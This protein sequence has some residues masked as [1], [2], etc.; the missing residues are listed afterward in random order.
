M[1]YLR[2]GGNGS[3]KTLLTLQDV[4]EL[5]LETNRPVCFN[6]RPADHPEKPNT[7]YCN[8]K[9]EIIKQFGWTGIHFEDW[10]S[11]APGTIFLIDECHYDLPKRGT[12]KPAT[13]IERLTEHRALGFDF[14]LLTQHPSNIDVFVRKLVQAPGWHQHIKRLA[15]AL[16]VANVIQWDAVNLACEQ[17]GSGKS[18]EVKT[19]PY[20][21]AVYSWYDSAQLHTGKVRIPKAVFVLVACVVAIPLLFIRGITGVAKREDAEKSSSAVV[22][23]GTARTRDVLPR[24][25]SPGD[26]VS[27]Y[28][29]RV[30]GLMHTAPAYD[31]M[32]SPRRVPV[33]AACISSSS[34]CPRS[35]RCNHQ[36]PKNQHRANAGGRMPHAT[37]SSLPDYQPSEIVTLTSG[38]A[39]PIPLPRTPSGCPTRGR[40]GTPYCH[41]KRCAFAL[42]VRKAQK[43]V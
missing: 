21:K 35:I 22:A 13:H 29:P 6:L 10:E 5:Q 4:R 36:L 20:P 19:R 37:S 18:G 7:P 2:T 3:G 14:F 15:G 8:L 11:Q 34:G 16:P 1:F 30:E 23:S 9:P 33:P 32:T 26:Y 42:C 40:Y 38:H 28:A 27:A 24:F 41:Q 25:Q 31:G 43:T 12:G 17:A 39:A